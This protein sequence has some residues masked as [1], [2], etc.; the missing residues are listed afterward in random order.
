MEIFIV[1]IATPLF[2]IVVLLFTLFVLSNYSGREV[3]KEALNKRIDGD[4][5]NIM[6]NTK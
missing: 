2:L 4:A 3:A 6:D 5:S 1:I